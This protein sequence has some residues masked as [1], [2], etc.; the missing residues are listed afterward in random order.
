MTRLRTTT[1]VIEELGGPAALAKLLKCNTT[2]VYNW[3]KV[4]PCR[5][6]KAI[7]AA[8]AERGHEA[9]DDLWRMIPVHRVEDRS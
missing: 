4:F 2:A 3:R 9:S 1:E 7:Q 6:Y 5:T 8:L